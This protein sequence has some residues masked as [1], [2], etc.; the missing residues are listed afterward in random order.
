MLVLRK[1][2][3]SSSL[4]FR[5]FSIKVQESI[6]NQPFLNNLHGKLLKSAREDSIRFKIL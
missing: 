3:R 1:H 4:Y 2:N 6:G 5:N